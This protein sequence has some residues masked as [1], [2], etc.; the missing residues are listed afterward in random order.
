MRALP[1]EVFVGVYEP[2]PTL[3]PVI[4]E[5]SSYCGNLLLLGNV[6]CFNVDT[7]ASS[8][9]PAFVTTGIVYSAVFSFGLR[10]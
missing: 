8:N 10:N 2:G 7:S 3:N 4:F 9:D 1:I 5:E 6:G